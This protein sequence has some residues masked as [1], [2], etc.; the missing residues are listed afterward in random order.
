[1][2][3]FKECPGRS[4]T[5]HGECEPY[6][7]FYEWSVKKSKKRVTDSRPI[8]VLST[9]YQR[10]QRRFHKNHNNNVR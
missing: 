7:K 1:M 2:P 9:R 5:C 3:C 10:S 6:L 8:A 4:P